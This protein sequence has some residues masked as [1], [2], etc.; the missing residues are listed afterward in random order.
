RWHYL[1]AVPLQL[2]Y[3]R[4][5]RPYESM[6]ARSLI[7]LAR[8]I[9]EEKPMPDKCQLQSVRVE[10]E[11]V[12]ASSPAQVFR[13]M[14]DETASWWGMPYLRNP[15]SS[16][17]VIEPRLG[18]LMYESWGNENEGA[19]CARVTTY[20][21]NEVLELNGRFGLDGAVLSVARFELKAKGDQ[22]ILSLSHHIIGELDS[23][24]KEMY[25]FGWNDLVGTRLKAFVEKGECFGIGH[26]PP[27]GLMP[28]GN[29]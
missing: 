10:Q 29:R 4:W 8:C 22:T 16:S 12:I 2:I 13:A 28:P 9:E 18:G 20:K 14:V 15:E 17:L 1:N 6:W 27:P 19:E 5:I 25:S 26:P 24:T 21:E 11:I 3:E 23:Q 7:G